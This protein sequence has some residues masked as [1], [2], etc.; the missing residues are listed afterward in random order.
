[1]QADDGKSG[2][3]YLPAIISDGVGFQ[4]FPGILPDA[5]RCDLD[6]IEAEFG[7]TGKVTGMV[8]GAE[9]NIGNG[10]FQIGCL[11][12][13][14][15]QRVFQPPHVLYNYRRVWKRTFGIFC[16]ASNKGNPGFL[17]RLKIS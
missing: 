16:C 8:K 14:R 4:P 3:F 13:E 2:V 1:M 11:L 7:Q 5:A 17:G 10:K 6:A 9:R 12:A 15:L